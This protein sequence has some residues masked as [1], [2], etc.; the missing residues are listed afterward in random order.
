M[1]EIVFAL[2]FGM[3]LPLLFMAMLFPSLEDHAP[4]QGNFRDKSVFV[5][6][7]IVWLL[8]A[9][10]IWTG[11]TTIRCVGFSV[12]PYV[13][14]LIPMVPLIMGACAF[15]LFDDW[16]GDNS[17]KG[18]KGHLRAFVRGKLTTGGLKMLGIG[19]IAF[20]LSLSYYYTDAASLVTVVLSTCVIA[21]T[22]NL[23]NLFDLRPTRAHKAYLFLLIPALVCVAFA[24]RIGLDGLNIV[25]LA[26]LALGPVL[27]VWRFDMREQAML[28]DAG[29]NAMGAFIG[30]LFAT[31]L[32]FW[33]LLIATVL[34]FIVNLLSER[35]S[36]TYII[37][38]HPLLDRFDKWGRNQ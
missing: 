4:R 36:F 18:F 6:L 17:Y 16:V 15:G 37:A 24:P 38:S 2:L 7:G 22:T 23:M 9:I 34:L 25:S 26:L 27:A 28:G 19:F 5:G 32:P 10:F 31:A 35:V 1:T 12:P 14:Y 33:G 20:S 13:E 11:A 29:A 21:L 30:Y 8:W 3:L